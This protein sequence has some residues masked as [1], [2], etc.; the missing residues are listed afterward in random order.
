[1]RTMEQQLGHS[2]PR[3]RPITWST[4]IWIVLLALIGGVL[5]IA[6]SL[7]GEVASIGGF[8]LLPFIGA[9]IIEEAFKPIGVYLG[10]ARWPNALR[11]Q[12]YVA[13]LCAVSGIV[14]GLL[15]STMYVFVYAPD[16]ADSY[17]AFRYTVPVALHAVA[18][19]TVGLGLSRGVVDW[20]TRGT[21]IPK[22][23]RK[24]YFAGVTIHAIYNTTVIAL[25]I[26]GV[27]DF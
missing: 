17:V 27:L 24:F 6:G 2:L 10:L 3:P 21:P 8:F 22:Q 12:L 11:N 16:E 4:H 19:F 1:M 18:S 5:G 13:I 23:A 9:P 26:A 20:V 15:E 7:F 14:F 25:A